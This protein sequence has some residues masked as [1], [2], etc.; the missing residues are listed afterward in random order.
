MKKTI[1]RR[2][3][4]T[5]D[6]KLGLLSDPCISIQRVQNIIYALMNNEEDVLPQ[7]DPVPKEANW[8][9]HF[10]GETKKK[11]PCPLTREECTARKKAKHVYQTSGTVVFDMGAVR[12]IRDAAEI[13]LLQIF[14]HAKWIGQLTNT[15]T[16]KGNAIRVAHQIY[17]DRFSSDGHFRPSIGTRLPVLPK[18]NVFE[19]R[20]EVDIVA[21]SGLFVE[22]DVVEEPEPFPCTKDKNYNNVELGN[23]DTNNEVDEVAEAREDLKDIQE[24]AAFELME[25]T[26]TTSYTLFE[27]DTRACMQQSV[28]I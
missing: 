28:E 20:T 21:D 12:L 4:E 18:P 25:A 15:K 10:S 27:D 14:Q 8:V 2:F 22:L 7:P 3:Y 26:Q 5:P 1:I 16:V 11:R 6:P 19:T 9:A 23:T 13:H 17:L 24:S